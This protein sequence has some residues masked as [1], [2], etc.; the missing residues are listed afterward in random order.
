[1]HRFADRQSLQDALLERRHNGLRIAL[2][3]TMGNLHAGHLQLVKQARELADYTVATIFVNPLQF[4][5]DEDLD[6]Y[7]RTLDNDCQLLHSVQ[8]DAVFHPTVAEVY[9]ESPL[10][11]QTI[12]HV[13]SISDGYCGTSRPGHFDG[14]AT[15]VCKLFNLVMPDIAVFG[16]KDYQ[17]FLV[18]SQMVKDLC[19]PITLHGV[20]IVRENS[21]LAM[22]SRNGYLDESQKSQARVLY[23]TLIETRAQI[24]SG[25]S[26]FNELEAKAIETISNKGLRP[27]YFAVCSAQTLKPACL[28]DRQLV[29]LTA[30]FVGNSRLIDNIR[31]TV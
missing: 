2:V 24:E 26:N 27:D 8:C 10:S 6:A 28:S 12:V 1:M 25:N 21:G 15:V 7:P 16:L 23:Q 29:I 20:E 3:P 19:L 9:G 4:G 17:Q 22:S 14:V 13:P 18:I 31:F 5:P 30:A 11:E